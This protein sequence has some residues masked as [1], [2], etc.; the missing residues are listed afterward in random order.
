M[1][2]TVVVPTIREELDGFKEAMKDIESSFT[3]PT[4]L[5]V[6][7]GE[8]GKVPTL[9]RAFDDI[10]KK[11]DSPIYVTLDDDFIPSPG[12]QDA[13][14]Q[15]FELRSDVGVVCPWLGETPEMLEYV[16]PRSVG[17]WKEREGL[18]YRVLAP[19]RHIP[20]CL[21][22]FRRETAIAIGKTP[23]SARKYDIYEDCW[24]GRMA[25]KL[26]WRS[27]YVEAGAVRLLPYVDT[28]EYVNTKSKDIEDARPQ[29]QKILAEYGIA[30][31][32]SWRMRQLVARL[33]GRAK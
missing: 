33:L 11:T 3:L 18:R 29:T 13:V 1:D 32:L 20:G 7:H 2:Y 10:L 21:L 26:G 31:P 23:E 24:R 14:K 12:W 5:R 30:D 6:I 8:G 27:A 15:M 28:E 17:P 25:Y 16:G 9:N 22:A 19:W 4:D